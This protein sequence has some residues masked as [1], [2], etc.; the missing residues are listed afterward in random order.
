MQNTGT[1]RQDDDDDGEE[2]RT[3]NLFR[4]FKRD[5]ENFR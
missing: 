2:N 4:G 1:K 5:V 3:A